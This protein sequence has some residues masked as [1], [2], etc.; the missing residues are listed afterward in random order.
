CETLRETEPIAAHIEQMLLE[1]F[2]ITHVTLQFEGGVC[3]T[4]PPHQEHEHDHAGT[5]D[6]AHHDH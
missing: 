1:R 5:P 4:R 2:G 3:L 6:H